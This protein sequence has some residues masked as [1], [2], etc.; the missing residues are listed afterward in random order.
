MEGMGGRNCT[1][2][3]VR[4]PDVSRVGRIVTYVIQ[5]E[6]ERAIY[7]ADHSAGA[8][9]KLLARN[10]LTSTTKMCDMAAVGRG[11]MSKE[12]YDSVIAALGNTRARKCN[13]IPL[14]VACMA[15]RTL[16]DGQRTRNFLS[17]FN[18]PTPRLWEL[19]AEAEADRQRLE[20]DLA[21]QDEIE[22]EEEVEA[23]LHAELLHTTIP[24]IESEQ[25]KAVAKRWKIE[26]IPP[27]L[28]KQLDA[29]RDWRLQPLNYLRCGNAVVDVTADGD[30]GNVLRFLAFCHHEHAVPPSL[31]FFGSPQLAVLAQDWLAKLNEKGLM[32]STLGTYTN[33]L[34]NVAAYWWDGGGKIEDSAL[35]LDPSPPDSLL[36]LRS[37]CESQAK[38]QQLYAKKPANWLDWEQAEPHHPIVLVL[39]H[40]HSCYINPYHHPHPP[41][42]YP[43]PPLLHTRRRKLASNALTLGRIPDASTT[44]PKWHC[45]ENTSFFSF[46]QSCHVSLFASNQ[47]F[48][49]PHRTAP[50]SSFPPRLCSGPRRHNPQASVGLHVEAGRSWLLQESISI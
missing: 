38:Q 40:A 43:Y 22:E 36:R 47:P 28:V 20:V 13:L 49:S 12:Q 25:D 6:L 31:D 41:P 21:L 27:A 18:Q 26:T 5:I 30:R 42:H 23:P 4:L 44:M 29:Y 37:Q 50:S 2:H 16:G 19:R 17:C 1:L 9:Y 10:N 33:S 24:Y 48:S 32:W 15:I 8:V 34:C 3:E 7:G 45:F 14:P 11:V 46:T 39:L 35:E